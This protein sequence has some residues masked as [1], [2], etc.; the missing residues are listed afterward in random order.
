M[1][2]EELENLVFKSRSEEEVLKVPGCAYANDLKSAIYYFCQCSHEDFFPICSACAEHCHSKHYPALRLQGSYTCLCGK[3]NHFV[4]DDNER[5]IAE[6]KGRRM[7]QCFFSKL[8]EI[9]PNK[10]YYLYKNKDMCPVCIEYCHSIPITEAIPNKNENVFCQCDKHYELN[11]INLNVDM[12]SKPFFNKY[13]E[14]INYNILSKIEYSKQIYIDYL[15]DKIKDYHNN[16][17]I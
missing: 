15:I 7:N 14:S 4:S 17:T 2:L 8:M 16:Q 12:L 1:I 13:F 3:N 6:K 5:R 11:V 9:T 10:G